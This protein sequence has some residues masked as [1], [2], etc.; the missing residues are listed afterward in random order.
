MQSQSE[1]E[2]EKDGESEIVHY[3]L[4]GDARKGKCPDKCLC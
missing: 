4:E 2:D 3:H 1:P